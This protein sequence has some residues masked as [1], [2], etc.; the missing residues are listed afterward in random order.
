MEK[1]VSVRMDLPCYMFDCNARLRPASFMDIAQALAE[2]GSEQISATDADLAHHN[3]AW[4]L[5]RMTVRFDSLPVRTDSVTGETW[6]RGL[7][8]LFY[9]RDY[10]LTGA[11]G[12]AVVR[13]GSSWILMDLGTRHIVYGDKLPSDP[14]LAFLVS[15]QPQNSERV[16]SEDCAKLV[17]PR[18]L[19]LT[20]AASHVVVYSDLDYNGHTNNAKYTVWSMDALPADFVT[21]HFLKEISIN[22]NLESHL[23]DVVDLYVARPSGNSFFVVGKHQDTQIFIAEL[24]FSQ[25]A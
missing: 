18:D 2:K 6:H 15:G 25:G 1:K 10:Q 21:T 14:T 8:G 3:L 4:V 13:A 9:M 16:L 7:D 11:S 17:V 22:F 20:H 23:G 19:P 24:C 12:D 5:A